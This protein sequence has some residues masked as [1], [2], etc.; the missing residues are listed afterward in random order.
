MATIMA[1]AVCLDQQ[2][3]GP[4]SADWKSAGYFFIPANSVKEAISHF[5]SGDFDL[6]MLGHSIPAESR[7]RLTF[8]IR[9]TGSNVPVVCLADSCSHQDSF[10]DATFDRASSEILTGIDDLLRTKTKLK[11]DGIRYESAP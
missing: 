9:S 1:L 10:A 8:L 11:L 2:F 4:Q 3:P 6:V 7:E 5:K